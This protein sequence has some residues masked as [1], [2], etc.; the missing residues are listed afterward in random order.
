MD[1]TKLGF[2]L[3]GVINRKDFGLNWNKVLE[4]GGFAVDD[5]VKIIVDAQVVEINSLFFYSPKV[6]TS[7][8]G[9]IETSLTRFTPII[10]LLLRL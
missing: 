5:M 6:T 3:N 9:A 10:P 8:S 2:S 7:P 1:Q 4:T